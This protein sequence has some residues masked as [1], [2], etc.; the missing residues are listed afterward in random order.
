MYKDAM[1]NFVKLSTG[2]TGV[3]FM[4]SEGESI[5]LVGSIEEY[6]LKIIGAHFSVFFNR[7]NSF[8]EQPDSIFITMKPYVLGMY[9]LTKD[10]F[11]LVLYISSYH[12]IINRFRIQQLI[13][14]IKSS[15]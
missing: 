6:D 8:E 4:D 1:E 3:I 14:F 11:L 13:N 15:L 2:V 12:A 9:R 5:D 10:Y 7:I